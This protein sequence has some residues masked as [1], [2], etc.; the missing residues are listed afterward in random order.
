MDSSVTTPGVSE[1]RDDP[2]AVGVVDPVL[3]EKAQRG[4]VLRARVGLE[5][6]TTV[7]RRP[8]VPPGDGGSVAIIIY[9]A[10]PSLEP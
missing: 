9:A 2:G 10:E 6:V 4:A 7:R 5:Q 3:G 1:A 8:A